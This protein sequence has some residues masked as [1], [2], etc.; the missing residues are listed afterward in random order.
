MQIS[1]NNYASQSYSAAGN[2]SSSKS[3]SSALSS[4]DLFNLADYSHSSNTIFQNLLKD[5]SVQDDVS[6]NDDGTYSFKQNGSG[7]LN[8]HQFMAKLLIDQQ[9]GVRSDDPGA[10]APFSVNDIEKFRQLTG[11]NLIQVAG[12]YTV[13]DDNGDAPAAGDDQMVTA[14]WNAFD[15]AKGAQTYAGGQGD[16]T[17]DDLKSAVQGLQSGATQR[18][19]S[20]ASDL[21]DTL[22]GMI[23]TKFPSTSDDTDALGLT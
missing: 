3:K 2:S 1:G 17:V 8:D 22:L 9:N 12:G 7:P 14:A 20:A 23:N 13:A 15:L 18:G 6:L 21:L 4:Q 16:L 11:Y 10:V 5:P 19:D